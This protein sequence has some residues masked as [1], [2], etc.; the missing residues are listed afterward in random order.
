MST[1]CQL[2]PNPVD[3]RKP[4]VALLTQPNK[5]PRAV[6]FIISLGIRSRAG[7]RAISKVMDPENIGIDVEEVMADVDKRGERTDRKSRR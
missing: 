4:V 3:S 7:G 5:K 1:E 2:D 6:P